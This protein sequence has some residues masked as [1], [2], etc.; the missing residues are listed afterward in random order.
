MRV[1]KSGVYFDRATC[2]LDRTVVLPHTS[3]NIGCCRPVEWRKWIELQ[4]PL[5]LR[6]S[7][8]ALSGRQQVEAILDVCKRGVRIELHTPLQVFPGCTPIPLRRRIEPTQD[9]VR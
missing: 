9:G 3:K 8:G 6:L 4:C 1:S 5:D 7:V 2:L